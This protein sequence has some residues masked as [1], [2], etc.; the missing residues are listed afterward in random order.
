MTDP[1]ARWRDRLP[2]RRP[3][4]VWRT[5]P[6]PPDDDA[7][8][9]EWTELAAQFDWFDR[10]A[11]GNRDVFLFFKILTLLLGGAVTVLAALNSAAALTASL[12]ATIVAAEG[13]QQLFNVQKV[14]LDYRS[15]ALAL[16]R[17]AMSFLRQEKPYDT[18]NKDRLKTLAEETEKLLAKEASDWESLRETQRS[19]SGS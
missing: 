8:T 2:S 15:T 6:K 17:L 4:A 13:I 10:R 7:L 14:W 3:K 5:L 19:D 16:R 1:Q 12:A 9:L 18:E 11:N